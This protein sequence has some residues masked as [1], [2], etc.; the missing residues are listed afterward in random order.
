MVIV[1]LWGKCK[2]FNLCHSLLESFPDSNFRFWLKQYQVDAYVY[3]EAYWYQLGS[4][5]GK[6]VLTVPTMYGKLNVVS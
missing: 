4:N 5:K 6:R 3:E 1:I 2:L